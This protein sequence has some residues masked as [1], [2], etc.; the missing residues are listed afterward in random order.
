MVQVPEPMVV[1]VE[2]LV[3]LVAGVEDAQP[4]VIYQA[5]N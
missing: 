3:D 4:S 5:Q 2:R 1:A